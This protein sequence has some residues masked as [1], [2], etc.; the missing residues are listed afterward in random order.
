AGD[1]A[2][3]P[4][5]GG[6]LL[7]TTQAM[8]DIKFQYL[9]QQGLEAQRTAAERFKAGDA[10]RALE[11]LQD[12]VAELNTVQLDS[13]R[14]ALLRRPIDA[15]LLQFKTLAGQRAFEK[16]MLDQR[17]AHSHDQSR[18]ALLQENKKKKLSEL[19]DEYHNLYSQG[20][21]EE[22]EVRAMAAHDLD[23]DDTA[24]A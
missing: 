6:D 10:E 20:K 2:A 17:T 8:Q 11:I 3:A 4:P 18:L 1:S 13:D 16:N 24:S 21:Y 14:V 22:A 19:M 12:Y 15:R 7:K 23:P 5:P 9:R